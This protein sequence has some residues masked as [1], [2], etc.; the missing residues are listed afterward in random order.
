[1]GDNMI[2]YLYDTEDDNNVLE[3]T[4]TNKKRYDNIKL[5]TP[6][7]IIR[8]FLIIESDI[9]LLYNYAYI[10]EFERYYF[11]ENI[12][13]QSNKRYLLDLKVDVLMS[14]KDDILNAK[15]LITE[16]KDG[17]KYI[18]RNKET[19]LRKEFYIYE[20]DTELELED[21]IILNVF[22]R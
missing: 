5:K 2:V 12:T 1:M 10:P 4:L 20:S 15:G 7:D 17:N 19:E 16:D 9:F 22:G 21:S 6:I 3:K 13:N 18:D 14:F 8:P 11:I